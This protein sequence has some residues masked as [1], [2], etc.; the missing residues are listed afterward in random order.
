MRAQHSPSCSPT[1]QPNAACQVNAISALFIK[2][3]AVSFASPKGEGSLLDCWTS[4]IK[5]S[6]LEA[7]GAAELRLE[8][9][10]HSSLRHGAQE[11]ILEDKADAR[12]Q[13]AS[14]QTRQT[15]WQA[16]GRTDGQADRQTTIKRAQWTRTVAML[17]RHWL[18]RPQPDQPSDRASEAGLA[19]DGPYSQT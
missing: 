4:T 1:Q 19:P 5:F 12:I 6:K 2:R 3:N 7:P 9:F 18:Q 11:N 15:G 10:P 8:T 13:Y 17:Y 14:R 16:G